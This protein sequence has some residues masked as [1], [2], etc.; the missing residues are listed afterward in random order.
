MERLLAT[1][2]YRRL[3]RIINRPWQDKSDNSRELIYLKKYTVH[4]PLIS[5]QVTRAIRTHEF[6][7]ANRLI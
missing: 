6:L 2:A 5:S 1:K 4:I 3:E 7:D